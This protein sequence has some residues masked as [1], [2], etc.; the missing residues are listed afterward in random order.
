MTARG[1]AYSA[2]VRA[3]EARF[4]RGG[5]GVF[6]AWYAVMCAAY[7]WG[8]K[9]AGWFASAAVVAFAA[10][11]GATIWAQF[12]S[13][14]RA[15]HADADGLRLGYGPAGA[16]TKR[17]L[18]WGDVEQLRISGLKRGVLLEVLLNAWVPKP[19]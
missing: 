4:P 1:P 14:V 7:V 18:S 15:F 12:R 10:A 8:A 16:K 2:F 5:V 17:D 9:P 19:R 6:A 13:G 11:A 3:A